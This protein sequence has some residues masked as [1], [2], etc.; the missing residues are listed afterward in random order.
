MQIMATMGH[1]DFDRQ[2]TTPKILK[3]RGIKKQHDT[4]AV[5]AIVARISSISFLKE[6]I[7]ESNTTQEAINYSTTQLSTLGLTVRRTKQ[8]AHIKRINPKTSK[9]NE[10]KE[11]IA[12]QEEIDHTKQIIQIKTKTTSNMVR[13]LVLERSAPRMV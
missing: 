10:N 8:A 7:Q 3:A 9:R 1:D 12:I 4:P 5:Q 11:S 2:I 6:I 13:P